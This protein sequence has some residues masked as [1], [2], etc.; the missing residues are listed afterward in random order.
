MVGMAP[1]G[2]C[3]VVTTP[4]EAASRS[5]LLPDDDTDDERVLLNDPDPP[6]VGEDEGVTMS[7]PPCSLR[8]RPRP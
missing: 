6:D 1:R 5:R 4:P 2:E 7:L 3:G 8:G